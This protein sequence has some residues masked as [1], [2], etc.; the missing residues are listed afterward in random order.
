MLCLAVKSALTRKVQTGCKMIVFNTILSK[1]YGSSLP[2]FQ[3]ANPGSDMVFSADLWEMKE[4]NQ[5]CGVV[6]M[7]SEVKN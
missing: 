7:E 3:R 4:G 2:P 5:S 6:L 1:I